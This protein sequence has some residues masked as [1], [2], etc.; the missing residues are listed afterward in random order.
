MPR[1][2]IKLHKIWKTPAK[3]AMFGLAMGIV[4]ATVGSIGAFNGWFGGGGSIP[5]DTLTRG[6][7]GYW[8]MD[9]GSGGNVYDSSDYANNGSTTPGVLSTWTKGKVGGGLSFDGVG[10]YVNVPDNSS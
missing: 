10:D 5:S 2:K 6:L 3:W 7:V 9:E 4:L 8:P 1:K